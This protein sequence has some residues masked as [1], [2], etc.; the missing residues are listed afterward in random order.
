MAS[1]SKISKIL[2]KYPKGDSVKLIPAMQEVQDEFGWLSERHLTEVSNYLEVPP[3]KA[4]GVATFYAQFR[5]KPIGRHVIN[6]CTG[7]ACHVKGANRLIPLFEQELGIKVGETTEDGRYTLNTVACLGCC[8]L[9]PA[10]NIDEDYFGKV[11]RK[12]I[13]KILRKYD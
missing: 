11:T 1:S 13:K 7:T 10:V 2:S 8:S 6:L 4:Y 12:D 9:S 5:L 3:S